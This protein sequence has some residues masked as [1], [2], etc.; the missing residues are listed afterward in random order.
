[1]GGTLAYVRP[2]TGNTFIFV[3]SKNSCFK[4]TNSVKTE[5]VK[6]PQKHKLLD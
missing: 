6:A 4:K 3:T 5:D 2:D 1:M